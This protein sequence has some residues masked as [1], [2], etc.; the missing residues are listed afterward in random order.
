MP[1]IAT[2]T[3]LIFKSLNKNFFFFTLNIIF[4]ALLLLDNFDSIF[5]STLITLTFFNIQSLIILVISVLKL[6]LE[7]I[8]NVCISHLFSNADF[9]KKFPSQINDFIAF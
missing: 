3:S 1:S 4:C 9:K 6:I 8:T 7:F 2:C 5:L